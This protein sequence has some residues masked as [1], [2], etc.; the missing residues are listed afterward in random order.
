MTGNE[1][2]APPTVSGWNQTRKP[3]SKGPWLLAGVV[4]VG[5]VIA[6]NTGRLAPTPGPARAPVTVRGGAMMT[7]DPIRLTGDYGVTWTAS[8]AEGRDCYHGVSLKPLDDGG[9]ET[10]VSTEVKGTGSGT[11]SLYDLDGRYAVDANSGCDVWEFT[12]SPRS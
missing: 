2:P 7:S 12:F 3:T 5:L 1:P 11:T 6:S 4:L 8:N 9:R 10:L